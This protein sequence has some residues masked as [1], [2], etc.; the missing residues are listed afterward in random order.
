MNEFTIKCSLIGFLLLFGLIMLITNM[1]KPELKKEIMENVSPHIMLSA[2]KNNNKNVLLVNVLGD[3]I[4]FLIDC[5][6]SVNNISITK[7]EFN[8]YIEDK[9]LKDLDLVVLYCAS[10]SCGAAQNYFNELKEKGV[11]VNKIYDYKGALHEWAMYSVLFPNV[12]SMKNLTSKKDATKEEL[13]K[14]AEDTKHSYL[15]KDEKVSKVE[16]IKQLS[17]KTL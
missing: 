16:I 6:D 4:P 9:E 3:K 1:K 2:L 17:N 15:L 13:V 12:Y 7:E 5:K 14:L 10:W 11:N 8:K